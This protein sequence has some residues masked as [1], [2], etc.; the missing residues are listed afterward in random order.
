MRGKGSVGM[1]WV[2]WAWCCIGKE[3][4]PFSRWVIGIAC[5]QAGNEVVFISMYCSFR[6]IASMD[7]RR[8]QLVFYILFVEHIFHLVGT[9]AIKDVEVW[10]FSSAFVHCECFAPSFTNFRSISTFERETKDCICIIMIENKY[11]FVSSRW[12]EREFSCLVWIW[13]FLY[14]WHVWLDI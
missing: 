9:F 6:R 12:S 1:I 13:F 10:C 14:H 3:A 5:I 2:D 7:I 4:I 11:I 8:Y